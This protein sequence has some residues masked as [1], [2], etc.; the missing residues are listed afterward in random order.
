MAS[1]WRNN[2]VTNPLFARWIWIFNS[3]NFVDSAPP[4]QQQQL[5]TSQITT[6]YSQPFYQISVILTMHKSSLIGVF[7]I[8]FHIFGLIHFIST[9]VEQS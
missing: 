1:F 8:A 7:K 4:A 9:T 3:T 6:L 5:I 2:D